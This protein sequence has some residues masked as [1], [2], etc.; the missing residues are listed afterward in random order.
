MNPLRGFA[1]WLGKLMGIWRFEWVRGQRDGY[2][3]DAVK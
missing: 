1:Y 2:N 3:K